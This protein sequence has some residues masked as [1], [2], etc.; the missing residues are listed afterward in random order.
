MKKLPI[1]VIAGG[2]LF[3]A[4][5]F[6]AQLGLDND[7]GWGK[8]RIFLAGIG[9][10]LILINLVII[11]YESKIAQL[12]KKIIVLS[13]KITLFNTSGPIK[14]YILITTVFVISTYLYYAYPTL[15]TE[16][17]FDYYGRMAIAFKNKQLQLLEEPSQALLSLSDPYNYTL[18]DEANLV[19]KFPID[20]SLY[21]GKFY[22]YWGPGPSILLTFFNSEQITSIKDKHIAFIF[23]SGLF[24]YLL[25]FILKI[26][27][28]FNQTL[29]AWFV[30]IFILTFGLSAPTTWMIR[31]SAIYE[32]AIFGGQFFLIGGFYWIY[33]SLGKENI[34]HSKLLLGSIHWAFALAT[35]LTT[36]PTILFSTA[37]TLLFILKDY[38]AVPIKGIILKTILI[39][40][41]L[42]LGVAGLGWYNWARFDSVSE[43]GTR[44]Q[45]A[46]VDYNKFKETF[47]LNY[48]QRNLHNY[49]TYPFE[50]Q[51]KFPYLKPVE[52]TLS[53]ERMIGL[54]YTSP[55]ILF[56]FIPLFRFLYAYRA[57]QDMAIFTPIEIWFFVTIGA[58]STIMLLLVL[59]FYFPAT[60]YIED[61]I[62]LYFLITF[63]I[64]AKEYNLNRDSPASRYYLLL[65]TTLGFWSITTN[66]LLALP[67]EHIISIIKSAKQIHNWIIFW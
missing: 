29:P 13:K 58:S 45:L 2:I 4:A 67:K 55:W 54:V 38:R 61:F 33:T 18:R 7:A 49:F 48:I 43:F 34:S 50:I 12:F 35:R 41:P 37:T 6:A 59:S 21:K 17:K 25:L 60:R 5:I 31:K 65:F 57:K 1:L 8:G 15:N 51:R 23:I 19:G 3:S 52:N 40:L 44:Y 46:N 64:L 22:F 24:L 20:I 66:S 30:I 11:K 10:A 62:P 9:I 32:S 36:W 47:S 53:N 26:W 39:S 63:F 16:S 42:I 56:V 27:N 14:F 28:Q